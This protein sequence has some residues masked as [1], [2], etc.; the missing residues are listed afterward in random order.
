MKYI[1][2]LVFFFISLT[3]KSQNVLQGIEFKVGGKTDKYVSPNNTT[4]IS[5]IDGK[6]YFV[7]LGYQNYKFNESLDC[8]DKLRSPLASNTPNYNP[9]HFFNNYSVCNKKLFGFTSYYRESRKIYELY[10]NEINFETNEIVET[11]KI[12][13]YNREDYPDICGRFRVIKSNYSGNYIVYPSRRGEVDYSF[14]IWSTDCEIS[15]KLPIWILDSNF[16]AIN[17]YIFKKIDNIPEQVIL[18]DIETD[19][20]GN[21]YA[22]CEHVYNNESDTTS[23]VLYKISNGGNDI[24]TYSISSINQYKKVTDHAIYLY[25]NKL[26][27][28]ITLGQKK[29]AVELIKFIEI[30]CNSF[31]PIIDKTYNLCNSLH[32]S[33]YYLDSYSSKKKGSGQQIPD[34]RLQYFFVDEQFAYLISQR[35]ITKKGLLGD[36]Y[37]CK[38]DVNNSIPMQTISIPI[39][40][41]VGNPDLCGFALA[42]NMANT[43]SH[44]YN[45]GII[46]REDCLFIVFPENIN[47]SSIKPNS[48]YLKTEMWPYHII[49]ANKNSC[50]SIVSIKD[51]APIKKE[52]IMNLEDFPIYPICSSIKQISNGKYAIVSID[53]QG[54][55]S[56]SLDILNLE[57]Y[58]K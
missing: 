33:P 28:S 9:G 53:G 12:L 13:E 46:K 5:K 35:S 55:D 3:G 2:I 57:N 18:K 30:D 58:G 41:R 22:L 16:K 6:G 17:N 39:N 10:T 40:Q 34:L 19:S 29:D 14:K 11:K 56:I 52:K 36:I 44:N 48:M 31:K 47:Q 1:A 26:Y 50:L 42:P 38:I 45:Y 4:S 20:I 32:F 7:N 51:D 15:K 23:Y 49:G 25:K 43:I 24:K 27:C 21:I 54:P 8:K 37:I